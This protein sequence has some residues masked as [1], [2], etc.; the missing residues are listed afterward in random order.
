[1]LADDDTLDAALTHGNHDPAIA[2]F[3]ANVAVAW[4]KATGI[5]RPTIYRTPEGTVGGHALDFFKR[6]ARE[7]PE[8]LNN[9]VFV[10]FVDNH[11]NINKRSKAQLR[12]VAKMQKILEI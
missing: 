4:T 10:S 7:L 1:L 3:L 8:K 12:K 11:Y 2:T 5:Q 9:N 6:V